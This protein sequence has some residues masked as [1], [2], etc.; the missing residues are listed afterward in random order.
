MSVFPGGF[1][2]VQAADFN[3]SLEL[4]E[5]VTELDKRNT[6]LTAL[7][8]KNTEYLLKEILALKAR[9]DGPQPKVEEKKEDA[10]IESIVRRLTAERDG[11]VAPTTVMVAPTTVASHVM[12]ITRRVVHIDTHEEP[13]VITRRV[14]T[15][16]EPLE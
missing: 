6:E 4:C 7:L 12:P 16:E 2:L 1:N 15:H 11:R 8:A 14:D 9:I 13:L 5:R 3:L 10:D